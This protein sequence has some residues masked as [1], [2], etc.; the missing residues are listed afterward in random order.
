MCD[1]CHGGSATGT[2]H[3]RR[4]GRVDA[5]GDGVEAAEETESAGEALRG[6]PINPEKRRSKARHAD[7]ACDGSAAPD[8]IGAVGA[9]V[10]ASGCAAGASE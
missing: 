3:V 8:A 4:S 6:M 7:P 9:A 5:V 10:E 2:D 1:S